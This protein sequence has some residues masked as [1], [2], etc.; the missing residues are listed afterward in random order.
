MKE[1]ALNNLGLKVVSLF[2]AFGVWM[3]IVNISNPI[4][5]D[6][7]LVTVEVHNEKVLEDA[8]LTYEIV[9]KDVITVNYQ[10]RTRDRSLVKASDFHAYIDLQNL[11]DVTGAVP[12]TVDINKDKEPLVKSDTITIKPMVIRIRTE[13]LQRKKFDLQ[14]TTKGTPEEGYALGTKE[15]SAD[16]V[17]VEGPESQIGQINHVGI[18]IDVDNRN[19]DITGKEVPV[20]YD[21]N[22][23]IL[24]L[25][26]KVSVNRQEIDYHVQV[27][28]AKNLPLNF[29]VTGTVAKG[30]RYTGAECDVKSVPVAGTKSILAS[31][32][33]LP[34]SSDRLNVD[35]ATGDIVVQLDLSQYLPP[36]TWIEGDEYK[37]VTVKLKVEPLTTRVFTLEL[38]KLNKKGNQEDYDYTFDQETSDVTVKGLREDLDTLNEENLKAVLDVSNLEAGSQPGILTFEVSGGFEVVG[39]TPFN[40]TAVVKST[41]PETEESITE[42]STEAAGPQKDIL[43]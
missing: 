3:A 42:T 4:I 19:A 14:V 21:A 35:G 26:D 32:S 18:E 9:G 28:K 22:G 34:V 17:T 27:L 10:V 15:L 31:L 36:N 12:V 20:F 38:D 43:P 16:N 11:Y 13:K 30:F 39:Y 40:V 41:E 29:E 33:N 1:K 2:L 6:S 37:N 5:N 24:D 23:N 7:Q 8:D 25:G